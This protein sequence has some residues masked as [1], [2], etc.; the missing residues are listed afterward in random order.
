MAERVAVL[1]LISGG[2]FNVDSSARA[3]P[4]E[5]AMFGKSLKDCA[6]LMDEGIETILKALDGESFGLSGPP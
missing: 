2:R 3:M 4:G 1:D 6:K 5:F